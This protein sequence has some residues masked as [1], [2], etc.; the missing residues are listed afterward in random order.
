MQIL[1]AHKDAPRTMAK[2]RLSKMKVP[3]T[4][5]ATKKK[6]EN[7]PD[8]PIVVYRMSTHAS[9]ETPTRHPTKESKKE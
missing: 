4:T 9:P 3:M 5:R 7:G 8:A 6:A 1:A 2:I